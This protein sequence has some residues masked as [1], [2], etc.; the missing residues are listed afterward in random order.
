MEDKT[1][2]IKDRVLKI[3]DFKE[4]KKEDF[5]TSLGISYGNFKGKSKET[6]LNS[7][8]VADI[9][10]KFPD[11]D[12]T[13]L[14]TGNGS[15][16]KS[17]TKLINSQNTD[18]LAGIPLIP[19][20]AWA[21]ISSGDVNV[22]ELECERYVVPNFKGADFLIPVKGSSMEPKYSSGDIVAGKWLPLDT[23]FQWNKVYVLDTIQG[24]LIKR[25]QKGDTDQYLNIISENPQ[26]PAFQLP[27]TEIRKLALVLGVIR[28]E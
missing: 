6:P 18:Q 1:T 17:E 15:M 9:L 7:D 10:T 27:K 12:P 14:L 28:L 5:F 4:L 16:I 11:I 24:P 8:T 26:Y 20:F 13:W 19:E 23:F 2:K 3:S 21:G 25:V 22:L